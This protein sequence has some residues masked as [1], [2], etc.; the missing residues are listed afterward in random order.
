MSD[1]FHGQTKKNRIE[2]DPNIVAICYRLHRVRDNV[3][4]QGMEDFLQSL[5]S[6]GIGYSLRQSNR[7]GEKVTGKDSKNRCQKSR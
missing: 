5:G 4:E 1:G 3:I 6:S 7:L 2:Q